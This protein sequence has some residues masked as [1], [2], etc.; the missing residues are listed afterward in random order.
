M[1]LNAA[2]AQLKAL[3]AENTRLKKTIS[4]Q[5]KEISDLRAH[6]EEGTQIGAATCDTCKKVFQSGQQGL[7]RHQNATGHRQ[8]QQCATNEQV[9][10]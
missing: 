7:L 8:S 9:R 5:K 1:E 10:S 3:T 4:A 6:S 2:K